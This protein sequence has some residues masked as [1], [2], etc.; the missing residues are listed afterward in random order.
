MRNTII[1]FIIS[2]IVISCGKDK[3]TTSPQIKYKSV[4][5]NALRSNIPTDQQTLPQL[6]IELTD[7]E[8]DVGI[9]PGKDTAFVYIRSIINSVPDAQVDSF[10][11]PDLKSVSGKNFQADMLISP[12]FKRSNRP[13]PKTDTLTY[14]IYVKDYAKNK[15]NVI[16]TE[17]P[18]YYIIP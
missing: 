18:V 11:M 16:T 12:P 7:G 5:P 10:I 2:L 15:S 14:E 1:I 8:G 6:T 13:S 17:D 3:Y 9:D 4:Y